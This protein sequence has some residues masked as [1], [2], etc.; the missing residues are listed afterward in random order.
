[1]PDAE[2]VPGMKKAVLFASIITFFTFAAWGKVGGG[3]IIF[4]VKGIEN[5]FYSHDDHV[6]K[7]GL[8][9]AECHHRIY[10]ATKTHKKAAMADV[11]NGQSCG[12]C[13]NAKRTFGVKG[14]CGRCHRR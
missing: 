1:M 6:G 3:D 8:K 10:T 13:H 12:V 14:N 7:A 11:Q 4:N 2:G 5:V 9:C